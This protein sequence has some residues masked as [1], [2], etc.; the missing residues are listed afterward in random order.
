MALYYM[1]RNLKGPVT[2]QYRWEPRN[3]ILAFGYN[4]GWEL[5]IVH[6]YTQI[7]GE[8]CHNTL[9]YD[10]PSPPLSADYLSQTHMLQIFW[11]NIIVTKRRDAYYKADRTPYLGEL[12][13]NMI[14][15]PN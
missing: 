13:C 14:C 15:R 4:I 6:G 11:N 8:W 10:R 2:L 9:K 3:F 1:H 7:S 12:S 5:H